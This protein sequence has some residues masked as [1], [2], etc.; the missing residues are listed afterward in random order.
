MTENALDTFVRFLRALH[1]VMSNIDFSVEHTIDSEITKLV[2]DELSKRVS[3]YTIN[4]YKELV[5]KFS[6][7][8]QK[9][10]L[11]YENKLLSLCGININN[12]DCG[13]IFGSD[14]GGNVEKTIASIINE[15][16]SISNITSQSVKYNKHISVSYM[17]YSNLSTNELFVVNCMHTWWIPQSIL[18]CE[19]IFNSIVYGNIN[20]DIE[21]YSGNEIELDYTDDTF[22]TIIKNY[23]I[24]IPDSYVS[25]INTSDYSGG[26]FNNEVVDFKIFELFCEIYLRNSIKSINVFQN[27]FIYGI[28]DIITGLYSNIEQEVYKDLFKNVLHSQSIIERILCESSQKYDKKDI[29]FYMFFRYILKSFT[30]FSIPLDLNTDIICERGEVS[31][32]AELSKKLVN[33]YQKGNS[34]VSK[35][36]LLSSRYNTWNGA[37]FGIP[38]KSDSCKNFDFDST[39]VILDNYLFINKETIPYDENR[40]KYPSEP[41]FNQFNLKALLK[42]YLP[43]S[44]VL[45]NDDVDITLKNAIVY[46]KVKSTIEQGLKDNIDRIKNGYILFTCADLITDEII[47]LCAEN[48]IKLVY[49]SSEF[50]TISYKY[51]NKFDYEIYPQES[52]YR[53]IYKN[54]DGSY[55]YIPYDSYIVAGILHVFGVNMFNFFL[56]FMN[57]K[58][59]STTYANWLRNTDEYMSE[60][61]YRETAQG[62]VYLTKHGTA[63]MENAF[64]NTGEF[65]AFGLHT[66]YDYNLWMCEQGGITC[67]KEE[68]EQI[69]KL[70]LLKCVRFMNGAPEKL[71]DLPVFPTT[72]CPWLTHTDKE[73]EKFNIGTYNKIIYY[74]TKSD[75]GGSITVR[76]HDSK[77][78]EPDCWQTIEF[79]SQSC[80]DYS[81]DSQSL[82]CVGGTQ[83]LHPESWTYYKGNHVEGLSYDLRIENIA[84][85]NSSALMPTRLQ[86]AE[87]SN[88]RV[89]T[90]GNWKDI[91]QR[92]QGFD[93]VHYFS[94]G[95]IYTWGTPLQDTYPYK[96]AIY[97]DGG[98]YLVDTSYIDCVFSDKNRS[99]SPLMPFFM[100]LDTFNSDNP[101]YSPFSVTSIQNAYRSYS[102]DLPQGINKLNGK[103]YLSIPNG[104]DG[105]LFWYKWYCGKIYNGTWQNSDLI[106]EAEDN[107]SRFKGKRFQQKLV[108]EFT[109]EDAEL[110]KI[111]AIL[112][113]KFYDY[114][115][116]LEYENDVDYDKIIIT[117]PM[118]IDTQTKANMKENHVLLPVKYNGEE[119]LFNR[120]KKVY[121]NATI[122]GK[123]DKVDLIV[124]N[125]GTYYATQNNFTVYDK[126]YTENDIEEKLED[127]TCVYYP[128]IILDRKTQDNYDTIE[129]PTTNFYKFFN[130]LNFSIHNYILD[131]LYINKPDNIEP[132]MLVK[133]AV[134]FKDKSTNVSKYEL[135]NDEKEMMPIFLWDS[136]N[137]IL[138]Q[139]RLKSVDINTSLD[140]GKFTHGYFSELN[141]KLPNNNYDKWFSE[142]IGVNVRYNNSYEDGSI[143]AKEG[144]TLHGLD[145]NT[146][147]YGFSSLNIDEGYKEIPAQISCDITKKI[148]LPLSLYKIDFNLLHNISNADIIVKSNKRLKINGAGE[149]FIKNNNRIHL[150]KSVYNYACIDYPFLINLFVSD[151]E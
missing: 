107:L 104:W 64:M 112:H 22:N 5:C 14:F 95:T 142:D 117:F 40:Y 151:V 84:W 52:I 6:N 30:N 101:S 27:E 85:S 83:A 12:N 78:N 129:Y 89:F 126:E 87:L 21:F 2:L 32:Y 41:Q 150:R 134:C 16:G 97:S 61:Y 140:F 131:E 148:N 4:T 146:F 111:E 13:S 98:K 103:Y 116:K 109:P 69:N 9:N 76:F 33:F 82:Y 73:L 63:N 29:V 67:T 113:P 102:I 138:F 23:T 46:N 93:T 136:K 1:S 123:K 121:L 8:L 145:F 125:R 105:R 86:N 96:N 58:I 36:F 28:I 45:L 77:M 99:S 51:Y 25:S 128:Y 137:K 54:T 10:N 68:N 48:N 15:T 119:Y 149:S 135:S 72:G 47:N 127:L 34:K 144:T 43:N 55:Y 124:T 18:Y 20:V 79:G 39:I 31:D 139:Q 7:E 26:I 120:Y 49:I 94:C 143:T 122:K 17:N 53:D 37:T 11:D 80:V 70:G 74:A 44:T 56:S 88:F 106:H 91:W 92:Q 90:M 108:L 75:T 132:N 141:S 81:F 57:K 50:V 66:A 60:E 65:I 71:I 59:T 62:R 133:S 19:Q 24:H 38:N 118:P 114:V 115:L 110:D 130:G 42:F 147:L 35:W 3:Y 100:Y